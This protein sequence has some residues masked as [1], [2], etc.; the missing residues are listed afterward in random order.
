MRLLGAALLIILA[1]AAMWALLLGVAIQ[2]GWI[3]LR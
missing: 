3:V 1:V 2:A